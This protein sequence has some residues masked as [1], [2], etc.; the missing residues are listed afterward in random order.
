MQRATG[1]D[2]GAGKDRG[3]EEKRVPEDEMG[4]QHHRY[5][6]HEFQQTLGDSEGQ[7]SS[8]C[9]SPWGF[10]AGHELATAVEKNGYTTAQNPHF[11]TAIP[12]N[13]YSL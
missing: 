7:G 9:Y 4:G 11:L 13:N 3:Q 8:V 6:G 2:P 1:K 12:R 5:N 10:R